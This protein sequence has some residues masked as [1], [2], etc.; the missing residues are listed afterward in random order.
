M[1]T[2]LINNTN[3]FFIVG[4]GASAGGL[5][6]LKSFLD[7]LP[8]DSGMAF[9]IVQHLDPNHKSLLAELLAKHTNMN[10]FEITEGLLVSPNCV[11]VIPPNKDLKIFNNA[12]SSSGQ[13]LPATMVIEFPIN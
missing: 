8:S 2:P 5:E 4:I 1:K 6:A 12:V 9:I 10:V 11:Y 7:N 3:N 13:V